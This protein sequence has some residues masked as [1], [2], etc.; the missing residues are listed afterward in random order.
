M[1]VE[2]DTREETVVREKT[3]AD[4]G[5]HESVSHLFKQLRDESMTLIRQEVQLARTETMEKARMAA[6]NSTL[7]GVGAGVAAAGGLLILLGVSFI[8]TALFAF[9]GVSWPTALW[10]GPLIVGVITAVVGLVLSR[11]GMNALK[12][13]SVK[14]ER[15]IRSLQEDRQWLKQKL[16]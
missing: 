6:R 7:L 2:M 14:P 11:K 9:A 15:T 13:K 12:K 10:L 8:V 5:E 1:S 3:V 16:S 4:R